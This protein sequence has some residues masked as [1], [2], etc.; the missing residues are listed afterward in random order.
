MST[1]LKLKDYFEENMVLNLPIFGLFA[2]VLYLARY[3]ADAATSNRDPSFD[4]DLQ[5]CFAN[6]M[7]WI[8]MSMISHLLIRA[9]QHYNPEFFAGALQDGYFQNCWAA[10]K[11]NTQAV[12]EF[13]LAIPWSSY[14]ATKLLAPDFKREDEAEKS[15]IIF[16]SLAAAYLLVR[17]FLTSLKEK[18]VADSVLSYKQKLPIEAG[19]NVKLFTQTMVLLG[20]MFFSNELLMP[21][22]LKDSTINKNPDLKFV[23]S[24]IIPMIPFLFIR[25]FLQVGGDK[26]IGKLGW[27]EK[28]SYTALANTDAQN[29]RAVVKTIGAA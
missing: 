22:I 12:V 28:D 2:S 5:L 21:Q 23:L 6:F 27:V 1:P 19:S 17:P 9:R 26:L 14:G 15:G 24:I 25:A 3:P 11:G 16:T 7:L 10:F 4:I 13:G 20:F 18:K 29:Y 8:P